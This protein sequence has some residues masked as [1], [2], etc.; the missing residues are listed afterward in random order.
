[1]KVWMKEPYG[2]GLASRTGPESCADSRKT[3]RE[4][5]TGAH[6]GGVLSREMLGTQGANAVGVAE[7]NTGGRDTAST[8]WTLRGRRP[9]HVWNLHAREPGG[10]TNARHEIVS[11]SVGEGD[12]P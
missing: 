2:E 1:M 3:G 10:P 9:P 11:G 4:A 5:L 6:A 7:G 12:E 8:L